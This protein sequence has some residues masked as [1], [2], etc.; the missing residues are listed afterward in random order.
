MQ[1]LFLRRLGPFWLGPPLL[2]V[3][4][5]AVPVERSGYGALVLPLFIPLLSV[6]WIATLGAC[7]LIASK[8]LRLKQWSAAVLAGIPSSALL[9]W[10]ALCGNVYDPVRPFEYAGDE[11]HFL[12]RKPA[13]DAQVAGLPRGRIRVAAFDWD[14]WAFM[15]DGVVYDETDQIAMPKT[16][17][18][19][20]WLKQTDNTELSVTCDGVTFLWH[21]YY[22][23]TYGC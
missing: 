18:S 12:A 4:A 10:I 13:Y 23:V 16:R 11:L 3:A 5:E 14:G 20:L 22:H 8:Q 6:I 15:W 7:V 19:K 1:S 21:H 17:R 2:V 9:I